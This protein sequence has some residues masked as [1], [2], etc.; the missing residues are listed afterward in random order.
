MEIRHLIVGMLQTNCY[1]VSKD[2]R[3]LIIDPGD[4]FKKIKLELEASGMT[5][6][7][8]LLTH[9]HWDHF[10]AAEELKNAFNIDIYVHEDD[11]PWVEEPVKCTFKEF[12]WLSSFSAKPT[13]FFTSGKLKIDLFEFEVIHTP[14][15]SKGSS[16]FYFPEEG[17]IFTGDTLFKNAI[18]RTDLPCS[19]PEKMASSLKKLKSLP[20]KTV[21]YPGHGPATTIE[22]EKFFNIYFDF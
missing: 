16:C 13:R 21:V 18:G 9:G 6:V 3:A 11:R 15:H 17:V 10:G 22:A 7:A 1:L 4:D 12:E 20:E 19:E 2:H 14:G 8:V 5:P